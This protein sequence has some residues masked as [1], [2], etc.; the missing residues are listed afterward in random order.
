MYSSPSGYNCPK[1]EVQ[2]APSTT[3]QDTIASSM[4]SVHRSGSHKF[5]RFGPLTDTAHNKGFAYLFSE[6]CVSSNFIL[7][8]CGIS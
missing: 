3:L 7:L 4:P 1:T 6:I 8:L 5:L 2:N